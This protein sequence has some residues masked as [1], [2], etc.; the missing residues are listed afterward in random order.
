MYLT[1][2][3]AIAIATTH[4]QPWPP[5]PNCR[6]INFQHRDLGWT[7][8]SW[9]DHTRGEHT[10]KHDARAKSGAHCKWSTTET[11]VQYSTERACSCHWQLHGGQ[12]GHMKDS[13]AFSSKL[14]IVL[15][16]RWCIKHVIL[17]DEE[18]DTLGLSSSVGVKPVLLKLQ[19]RDVY[20]STGVDDCP[21][22]SHHI[23]STNPPAVT[24][25]WGIREL[26]PGCC[27]HGY[28]LR[29]AN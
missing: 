25:P 12:N 15:L 11:L 29:T 5:L 27:I 8:S 17:K 24:S 22:Q 20:D 6:S 14:I 26:F 7:Q 3:A 1:H 23:L 28:S 13:W 9:S 16:V 21:S 18:G 19:T 4:P 2:F 10:P